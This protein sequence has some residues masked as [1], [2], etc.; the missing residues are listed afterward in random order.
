MCPMRSLDFLV[1]IATAAFSGVAH[2]GDLVF[3]KPTRFL[4]V[5]NAGALPSEKSEHS[6]QVGPLEILASQDGLIIERQ[7][8]SFNSATGIAWRARTA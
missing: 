6:V 4:Q 3:F 2:A 1:L 8:W 7:R 5:Q